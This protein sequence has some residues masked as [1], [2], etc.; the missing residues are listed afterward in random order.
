MKL[1][2]QTP[3]A[4]DILKLED[5]KKVIEESFGAIAVTCPENN[6]PQ[7]FSKVFEGKTPFRD[8]VLTAQNEPKM[9]VMNSVKDSDWLY[10]LWAFPS[11][12]KNE[13]KRSFTLIGKL[14]EIENEGSICKHL[15][16]EGL[17][18]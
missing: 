17:I 8:T 6:K 10:L 15:V 11:D 5:L 13:L 7:N 1:V 12:K 3:I 4:D 18:H 14:L 9:F 16:D 2:I